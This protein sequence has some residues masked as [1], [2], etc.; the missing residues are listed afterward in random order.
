MTLGGYD[1][2]SHTTPLQWVPMIHDSGWYTVTLTDIK[3]GGQSIGVDDGQVRPMTKHL[4]IV[5][6]PG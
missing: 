1:T 2:I 5:G 6:G 4:L 3:V